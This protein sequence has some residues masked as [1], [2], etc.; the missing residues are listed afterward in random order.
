MVGVVIG[1]VVVNGMHKLGP[2][3]VKS[4]VVRRSRLVL[5]TDP[6]AERIMVINRVTGQLIDHAFKPTL[7]IY[8]GYYRHSLALAGNVVVMILDDDKEYNAFAIDGVKLESVNVNEI[9]YGSN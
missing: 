8:T 6:N 4:A 2:Q 3:I 9:Y 1:S 5:D 7:N